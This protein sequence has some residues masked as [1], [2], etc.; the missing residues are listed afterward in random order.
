MATKRSSPSSPARLLVL[1]VLLLAGNAHQVHGNSSMENRAN[2]PTQHCTDLNSQNSLD[3][4]QIMGIWYGSEVITHNGHDE[5]EVVYNTCVVIHLAD[6][7]NS[8]PLVPPNHQS[9]GSSPPY[10][11]HGSASSAS[12]NPNYR[13]SYGYGSPGSSG[14]GRPG[15]S[16][17]SS[18]GTIGSSNYDLY[19]Q[20]QYQL[21]AQSMRYLRLIWDESEHTL[22]YTLRYN[23][24]RPG[25]WIS[26]SPQ[27][28][29]MIQLQYV[30]FTGTVQVL[31]AINNQLVLTFCQ[32]IPSGQ[33][34]TVVLSRIP[35]GLAPEEI[36]SIRNL[37]RRRGLPA[38]SVR[39]VCQNGAFRSGPVSVGVLLLL[40]S[41]LSLLPKRFH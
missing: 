41:A 5:G 12:S 2:H 26:S 23:S 8:T 31:K 34:F 32:S 15:S 9:G 20:R 28:G 22:E 30:Q 25:F 14:Q 3:V 21:Q 18:G 35:M 19:Q 38:I 10:F 27:S 40:L 11:T 39:K 29:S 37:L 24:S 6:V 33:L 13:T 36:Q 17:S 16:S 7:T 1:L 4:E